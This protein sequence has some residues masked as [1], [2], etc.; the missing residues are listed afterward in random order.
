MGQKFEKAL[1]RKSSTAALAQRPFSWKRWSHHARMYLSRKFNMSLAPPDR[2]SVN[3]TLRCNLSCTMCTTCYDSPELSF[4]EVCRLIDE[5]ADWGVE[6]FNPLGGEPFMR[7]DIEDILSYA[8]NKGFFVSLTTNGTL[9]SER[10][11]VRIAKISP[12]RLH[13]NVSL[14]GNEQ[15]NDLIRGNGNWSR[16]IEGYLRIREADRNVGN[17]HR[18][19]LTNTI[20]HAHNLDHFEEVLDEQE[21]LGFD[22]VQI[23]NLFRPEPGASKAAQDLWFKEEQLSDLQILT[24]RLAHRVEQGQRGFVIQNPAAELR[25]IVSYYQEELTPLE[26]PCWSGF[27]ELYINADGKAIMCD[28]QLDFLNGAFGS[29]RTHT[30][31]QIWQSEQLQ[32]RRSVVRKCTTPCAQSCYLRAES[33]SGQ[34][35]LKQASV[36]ISRSVPAVYRPVT[37]LKERS[38]IL[39]LSDVNPSD[40]E[41]TERLRWEQ[42]SQNC[43]DQI[44]AQGWVRMR[45]NGEVSF[46]RGFMGFEVIRRIVG[47][48]RRNRYRL[49][50][51]CLGWR[52]EPLLHPEFE[53]IVPFLQHQVKQGLF[54]ELQIVTSGR[55]LTESMASLAKAQ[56][57]QVWIVDLDED[58]GSCVD[59]L[60]QKR[61]VFSKLILRRFIRGAWPATQ[62]VLR[63]PN[64]TPVVGRFPHS[65][66]KDVLWFARVD[67]GNHTLNAR[68]SEDLKRVAQLL[69]LPFES[70]DL[71]LEN[72]PQRCYAAERELIVSWDG[73]VALCRRDR[74]LESG[75]P[76]LNHNSLEQILNHMSELGTLSKGQGTPRQKM[77]ADCGFHWSP[78]APQPR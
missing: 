29:V 67:C 31:R 9:I 1:V 21:K 30:L 20:L 5:T 25:R 44:T 71:G 24:E 4:Q 19:I 58:G 78:N 61:S 26:A 43:T 47:E 57:P 8:V 46:D 42:L 7:G 51:V 70:E 52:G 56:V 75:L 69:H 2:V 66:H 11:A 50:R 64:F 45:D 10:R 33:D 74:F 54:Q 34:A 15:S 3:L 23:L 40:Q 13:F 18:K 22:G 16:A 14:D 53:S 49:K 73:K 41:G 27:K 62:D 35:L 59:M 36:Q 72:R 28:G 38:L 55:F 76:E 63:Y 39:E 60:L 6:V 37:V 17:S 77:C 12:D 32:E 68:A 48:L 65:A